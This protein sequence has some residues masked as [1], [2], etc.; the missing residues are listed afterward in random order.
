MYIPS[1]ESGGIKSLGTGFL[2]NREGKVKEVALT[3][4]KAYEAEIDEYNLTPKQVAFLKAYPDEPNIKRACDKALCS[5]DS[6]YRWTETNDVFKV[7]Y[8]KAKLE[9][10]RRRLLHDYERVVEV[11]DAV[12]K[13]AI[14]GKEN[15]AIFYLKNRAPDRW[16][17][18]Y[19]QGQ[20]YIQNNKNTYNIHADRVGFMNDKELMAEVKKL[21]D[22]LVELD[23]VVE[24]DCDVEPEQGK[25]EVGE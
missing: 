18:D 17:N 5:R 20:T 4:T 1:L 23:K 10:S 6:Y 15:S 16:Q 14:N 24:G 8:E 2:F 12:Y 22:R 19:V 11:E 9:A 21:T 25:A 3:R 13:N 7:A